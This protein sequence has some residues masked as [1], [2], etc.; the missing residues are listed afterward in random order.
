M[1]PPEYARLEVEAALADPEILGEVRKYWAD[2]L[3]T[4]RILRGDLRVKG[5]G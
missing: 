3:S 1:P 5:H 4:D 2:W